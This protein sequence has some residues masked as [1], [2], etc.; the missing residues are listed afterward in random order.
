MEWWDGAQPTAKLKGK[1]ERVDCLSG[2][3]RIAVRGDDKKL[4][5]L[6]IRNPDKIVIEG[7]GDKTLGCGAQRPPRSISVGYFPKTDA[8]TATSGEAAL[9]EF[10]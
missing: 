1:L 10:P 9:I 2:M 4:V 3:A 6:L 8:K 5:Q 7:G